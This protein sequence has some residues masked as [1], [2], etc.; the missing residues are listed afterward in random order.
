MDMVGFG[1]HHPLMGLIDY[2]DIRKQIQAHKDVMGKNFSGNYSKGIFPPE[3]AFADRIIPALVDEGIEWVLID[4]VHFDRACEGYPFSTSSNLYE[5]NKSDILNPDPNDWVQL[6]N[7]WAPTKISARW[8]HQPHYVEYVNPETG[9]K[10]KIIAVP[11]DRY[12]GNEDG[13][14]GFGALQYESVMSQLESYNTDSN[15]PILIVLHHDGDNYGGGTDS[16]Y[17][18]NFQAF[19]D[20]VSS[21]SDRFVCTTIQDYLEMFPPNETDIIHVESGSWSGADNGDPEFKKWLGDPNSEGYSPDRNSWGVVTATKNIVQSAEDIAPEDANTKSAWKYFL[22]SEASDYWYW[23]FSIDGIWDAHPTRASNLA[24]PF[25]ESVIN[26]SSDITP[27]TIFQPQREPYNPGGTEWETTQSSDFTVWTYV[28]DISGLQS[29]K[30]KYRLDKDG[31]NSL[32]TSDNEKYSGGND[33]EDW[34]ELIMESNSIAPQTTIFP[35]YKA[36]EYTAI[37]SGLKNELIDYYVEALD[38]KGNTAKSPISHVYIGESSGGGTG[39]N[40]NLSW[41]PENPTIEDEII[42]TISNASTFVI[43]SFTSTPYAPIF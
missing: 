23:D 43:V 40:T 25:A 1:Y 38:S 18:S 22:N 6:Q 42:I 15:H 29:V 17:G 30:L 39:G 37:I 10:S 36:D 13:R 11:T 16:Y 4:N 21:N 31:I 9:D 28:F 27:P 8:G 12:M 34:N 20:W 26:N 7:L 14:G 24:I 35:L 2:T 3:N 41:S 5:Q 19:V 33:V 32:S